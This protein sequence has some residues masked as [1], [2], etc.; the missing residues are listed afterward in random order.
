[1][2]PVA[3]ASVSFVAPEKS[4]F[5][6]A[7]EPAASVMIE[8]K[9][10]ATFSRSHA[11][12]VAELVSGAVAGLKP[13]NVKVIDTKGRLHRTEAETESADL[14]VQEDEIA[15]W[16]EEQVAKL[17]P[18][19][20]CAAFVRFGQTS[21]AA[22]D[23]SLSI[24]IP[25]DAPDLPRDPALREEFVKEAVGQIKSATGLTA[26]QIA[27]QILPMPP[28]EPVAPST[29]WAWAPA[30]AGVVVLG[31]I[32]VLIRHRRRPVAAAPARESAEPF[33]FLSTVSIDRT[34][35]LLKEEHA[36]AAALV[37]AHLPPSRAGEVLEKL[38]SRQQV[39]VVRRLSSLDAPTPEAVAQVERALEGKLAILR[40]RQTQRSGGPRT[41]A[42]ILSQMR[43][44][45]GTQVMVAMMEQD[46][47]M[48]ERIRRA[49]D[50]L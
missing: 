23:V 16:L 26:E 11:R 17:F 42:E 29:S 40:A 25:D 10:G 14:R 49:G 30:I 43:S 37:L 5:K 6:G 19:W 18:G 20:R 41:A 12:A 27:V 7:A 34:V 45:T 3:N 4:P 28:L 31:F 24:V 39:D 44:A 9:P 1:M 46:P 38:P 36:Q 47:E 33:E 2:E 21:F 22:P 15:A 32:A 48:A 35:M 50:S 13:S 8:V